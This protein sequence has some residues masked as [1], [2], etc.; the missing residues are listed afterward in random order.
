MRHRHAGGQWQHTGTAG[1]IESLF[2]RVLS[3]ASLVTGRFLVAGR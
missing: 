2:C 1:R 3:A